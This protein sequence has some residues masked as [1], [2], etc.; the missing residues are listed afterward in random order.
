[1]T[2]IFIFFTKLSLEKVSS[3]RSTPTINM[4]AMETESS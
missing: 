4:A 3:F 2:E 1:M